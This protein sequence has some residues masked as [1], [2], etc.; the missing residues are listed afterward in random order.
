MINRLPAFNALMNGTSAFLLV[1]GYILIRL[2][3]T[4]LHQMCMLAALIG[5]AVFLVSYV[6]YHLKVGHVHYL[7]L[8]IY[9]TVYLSILTTHT[10][11]AGL[12]VPLVLRTFYLAVNSRFEEHRRWARWTI[13][14]W[15]YVSVTG[16]VIYG[17]LY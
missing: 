17:M 9:R 4:Y 11:L 15:F 2:K 13:P 7:G 8:G 5:S 3:K 6:I 14:I 1:V 16:V 12:V 10:F